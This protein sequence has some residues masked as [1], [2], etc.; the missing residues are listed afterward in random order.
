VTTQLNR[1]LR[2]GL[3]SRRSRQLIVSQQGLSRF[4]HSEH[5]RTPNVDGISAQRARAN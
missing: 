2:M 1:F 3:L 4:T 5:S